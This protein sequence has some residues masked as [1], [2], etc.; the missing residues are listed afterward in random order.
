M[1]VKPKERLLEPSWFRKSV[2]GLELVGSQCRACGKVSFPQKYVC[3][4]CF[5]E[6]LNLVPL[7]RRGTLH[8]YA[9]STLGPTDME[10]PYVIGFIDLPEK[11][12]LFSVITGCGDTGEGLKIDMDME[13][14]VGKIKTDAAGCDVVSY[15]FRPVKGAN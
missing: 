5:E 12:K 10:K 1:E 15:L 2:K 9:V 13:M 11:I 14:V 8:T 7:S 3:P 4:Q 6:N